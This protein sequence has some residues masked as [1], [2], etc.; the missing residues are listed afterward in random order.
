MMPLSENAVKARLGFAAQAGPEFLG[1][2]GPAAISYQRLG[3]AGRNLKGIIL[4]L[5][6]AC[7][8]DLQL[9]FPEAL[10]SHLQ[11]RRYMSIL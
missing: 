4:G 10:F 11:N 7:F 6:S 2:G 5:K 9:K 3:S 1:S 8:L